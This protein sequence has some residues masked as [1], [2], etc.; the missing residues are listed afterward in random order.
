MTPDAPD[1][2]APEPVDDLF[3]PPVWMVVVGYNNAEDTIECMG[4]L[5]RST[6][7]KLTLLYVDNG[8]REEEAQRVREAF[9]WLRTIRHP[10][11]LG[12]ARGFNSGLAH[13]LRH[14]AA[15]VGMAHNDTTFD[16]HAVERMAQ[17]AVSRPDVGIVIPKVYCHDDPTCV[18]SAGSRVRRLPPS[19]VQN[20]G[21]GP[22]DGRFDSLGELD[23]ARFSAAL[24]SGELLREA[25]L[26]DA[27]YRFFHE[28]YD[29]C[30]RA[31]DHGYRIVFEPAADA[32][33]KASK[34]VQV[35]EGNPPVFYR[36][37][38]RS[39][40]I[41]LRKHPAHRAV[42]GRPVLAY[43][44][45]RTLYDGG[46][47]GLRAFRQ[48]MADGAVEALHDVPAWDAPPEPDMIDD[49]D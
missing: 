20:R 24:I 19:I 2:S 26:I 44:Y 33:H 35:G 38:G 10:E 15:Y 21:R 48:G 17:L 27:D 4:S 8:S 23:F 43:L 37:Y 1:I 5:R 42:A 47:A 34:T 45:A 39:H 49:A 25:G 16:E 22:D 9:P 14:G 11:N 3:A 36:A 12:G 31:Q 40:A 13:A 30:V 18:W 41:F 32:R 29:F 46:W 28:D 7:P 6:Y